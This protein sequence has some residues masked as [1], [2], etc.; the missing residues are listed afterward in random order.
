LWDLISVEKRLFELAK[1]T[2]ENNNT[3]ML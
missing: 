3:K 2:V 1:S